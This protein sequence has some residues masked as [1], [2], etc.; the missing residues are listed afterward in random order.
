MGSSGRRRGLVPRSSVMSPTASREHPGPRCRLTSV[1]ERPWTGSAKSLSQLS[2][3]LPTDGLIPASAD[4]RGSGSTGTAARRG[5]RDGS[6]LRLGRGGARDAPAPG[7]RRRS[8]APRSRAGP[9]A[10]REP[11]MRRARAS[12]TMTTWTKPCHVE[13]WV[14]FGIHGP[15]PIR[16]RSGGCLQRPRE[17]V[18]PRR[19]EATVHR[20]PGR[21]DTVQ[22]HRG[23]SWS[24]RASRRTMLGRPIARVRRATVRP[25]GDG[26]QFLLGRVAAS[27]CTHAVDA[28]V[29][30]EDPPDRRPETHAPPGTR[31]RRL[32]GIGAA[33]GM[34]MAGRWGQRWHPAD[35]LDRIGVAVII[36]EPIHALDRWSSP[37]PA[38]HAGA[39]R[40]SRFSR[41]SALI[42]SLP[43]VDTPARTPPA[44][45]SRVM[46]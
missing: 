43:S 30:F 9:C 26:E 8:S 24:G 13:T 4:A 7:R 34:G 40:S 29:S 23:S 1:L 3:T 32:A 6:T 25:A 16:P 5:H 12:I 31:S 39:R 27:S 33:R 15:R 21:A 11:T 14:R 46:V 10:T 2:P 42:R 19:L 45:V 37:A 41:S 36:D 35:R 38:K 17:R 44:V 18:R 22:T 28:E 20:P